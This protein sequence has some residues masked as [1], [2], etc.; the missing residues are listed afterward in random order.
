MM[1]GNG[2]PPETE[3][4]L[5]LCGGFSATRR[6]EPATPLNVREFNALASDLEAHGFSLLDLLEHSQQNAIRSD[7][8]ASAVLTPRIET[9][10]ARGT[11]LAMA[12]ERW[13]SLGF[14]VIDRTDPRYPERFHHHL[15]SSAPP[16]LYGA[17]DPELLNRDQS[18]VAVV[19]SRDID[20]DGEDFAQSVGTFSAEIGAITVSGGARGADRT[21][22]DGALEAGGEAIAILPGALQQVATSR[23]YRSM[24]SEGQFTLISPYHPGAKFTAGNAMGRNRLIYCLADLAIVVESAK[25]SGGTWTGATETITAGW[26]PVGVRQTSAPSDGN[27]ALIDFGA[28]PITPETVSS[29]DAFRNW[30]HSTTESH[31][32]PEPPTDNQQLRLMD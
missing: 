12:V 20:T 4:T 26:V 1:T 28:V 9:L 15:G 6:D 18:R 14:W 29:S 22:I 16:L 7:S 17:G 19:G 2:L 25:E 30:F 8:S 11:A 32:P 5:L 23:A 21:A 27:Q 13:S 31:Q 10:L 24:V 3:I